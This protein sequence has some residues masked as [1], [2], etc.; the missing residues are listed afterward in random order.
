VV[1][2]IPVVLLLVALAA[3]ELAE[4]MRLLDMTELMEQQILAVAAVEHRHIVE[5]ALAE[6]VAQV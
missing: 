2:L 4:L 3:V 6:M 1:I 5:A